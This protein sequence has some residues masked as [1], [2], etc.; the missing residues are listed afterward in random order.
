MVLPSPRGS[1]PKSPGRLQGN[2]P[3]NIR[4]IRDGVS[5]CCMSEVGFVYGARGAYL[6]SSHGGGVAPGNQM[7]RS[8]PRGSHTAD[9]PLVALA[10]SPV[11]LVDETAPA[12]SGG[13]GALG[14]W[15]ARMLPLLQKQSTHGAAS[16]RHSQEFWRRSAAHRGRHGWIT[17]AGGCMPRRSQRIEPWGRSG[18]GEGDREGRRISSVRA[19]VRCRALLSAGECLG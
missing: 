8:G 18:G 6:P 9:T 13:G 19:C 11:V 7:G 4:T 5:I 15:Q 12:P 2:S 3:R 10:R 16:V 14:A 1:N 17:L